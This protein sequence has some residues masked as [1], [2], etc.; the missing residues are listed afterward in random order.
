MQLPGSYVNER[1]TLAYASTVHAAHG[2]TVDAGYP[3]IGPGTDAAA[4]YV[5]L[6]R[7]RDT[8]IAFVV[9]RDV[10]PDADTGE[11]H[12]VA[13]RTAAEVLADVI[14]PPEVD[15]NRTALTE[16]EQHAARQRSTLTHVDRMTAVIDD[17]V[18]GRTSR[19]L[20]QLAAD[21]SLPERHRI[22]LAADDART[23]LA[24]L[25][26]SAELAGH[27]PT[28]V[29]RDAVTASSL[30][31]SASV[32]QVLHFRTRTAL[33]GKLD[34]Q[35]ATYADLLPRE[36]GAQNRAGLEELAAAADAR[37]AELGHQLADAPTQWA[38]EALG[39]VPGDDTG[40]AEWERKAG[41]AASY[42][43]LVEHTDD[44]DPLGAA[45]PAGLA[46]KHAVFRTAH[47]ALDLPTAGADEEA[48]TEGR[49]RVRVAAYGREEVWAPRYVADELEATHEALRRHQTDATVWAARADVA[50]NPDVR[51]Q[52]AAAAQ[53]ARD[54]AAQLARQVDELETADAARALWWAET[55][56]TRDKAERARVALGIRGIDLDNPADRVTA[57]EWLDAH[58]AEQLAAD[59]D[60]AITDHDLH[61]APDADVHEPAAE[62]TTRRENQPDQAETDRPAR[63]DV[64]LS[65]VDL[66]DTSTRDREERADPQQRHRVPR[67]DETAASAD[68]AQLAL[69]EIAARRAAEDAEQA[70]ALEVESDDDT[71]RDE[72]VRWA[73]HD[74]AA[75][76][77]GDDRADRADHGLEHRGL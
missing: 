65:A 39:P 56:V 16:A 10:A 69:A 1:V 75:D 62:Q 26:R 72:L 3:V 7:G 29:L 38:R 37:R 9:T 20:D 59:A 45:P 51:D 76:L 77:G 74:D 50:A 67:P 49:L 70:Q 53:Q 19:W 55:A 73:D 61:P 60:R 24:Q 66:R 42:R 57:Q 15:S 47:A 13:E 4:G 6:T 41:W 11:T 30:D 46:E 8:N 31:K 32:A 68:R 48:M 64:E 14:R 12:T 18:T 28:Q 54:Q 43:E 35:V 22:A 44:A 58:R 40:R 23:S 33:D 5:Q 21:G 36:I 63:G 25:L 27:D 71:R 17:T 2:R 34:P 52:L